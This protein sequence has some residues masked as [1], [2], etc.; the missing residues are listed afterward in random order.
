MNPASQS[1]SEM[2]QLQ[3]QSFEERFR[4]KA[5][6]VRRALLEEFINAPINDADENLETQG[7][8]FVVAQKQIAAGAN[9]THAQAEEFASRMD[10]VVAD[11]IVVIRRCVEEYPDRKAADFQ[12]KAARSLG[13]PVA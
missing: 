4:V 6:N 8:L 10:H 3:G 7:R 11:A 13:I 9:L 5:T 1:I 12:S 2:Y